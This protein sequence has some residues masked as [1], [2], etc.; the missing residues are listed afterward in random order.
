MNLL[1]HFPLSLYTGKL[2]MFIPTLMINNIVSPL[3]GAHVYIQTY[4]ICKPV[5]SDMSVHLPNTRAMIIMMRSEMTTNATSTPT[6]MRMAYNSTVFV[7][8]NLKIL[9]IHTYTIKCIYTGTILLWH[10]VYNKHMYV[11]YIR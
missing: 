7:D 2:A 4:L 11:H 6:G 10:T 8:R 5:E 9:T 1:G 3:H